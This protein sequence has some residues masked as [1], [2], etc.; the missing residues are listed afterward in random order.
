MEHHCD[1]SEAYYAHT[2]G[3]RVVAP[4]TPSDAYRLLRQSIGC[5]DPVVFLENEL[6]YGRS[7]EVPKLDDFVLP[8]GKARIVR[9][10]K[11]VTIVSYSIGVGVALASIYWLTQM[12]ALLFP[13]TA[14]VDPEFADRMPVIAGAFRMNQLVID[15]VFL[16]L[17]GVG[18]A[19][20]RRRA[21]GV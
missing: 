20:E 8:I 16:A 9:P 3:L 2:P 1:S 10:G 4:G 12:G 21:P 19:L 18:V 15:V 6:M 5:P 13:G 17:V 11:D 14:L 7:F